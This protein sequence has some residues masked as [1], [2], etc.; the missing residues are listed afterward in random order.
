ML[1]LAVLL[2]LAQSASNEPSQL[3]W[4]D[5]T[6][7]ELPDL[8]AVH[9]NGAISLYKN[10]GDGAFEEITTGSALK[11]L[12]G[13]VSIEWSDLDGDKDVDLLVTTR[14]GV[15][16]FE[17]D[18][19]RS[20]NE[21]TPSSPLSTLNSPLTNVRLHDFDKDGLIDLELSTEREHSLWHNKG[22]WSFEQ[23]SLQ[24]PPSLSPRA[25][26]QPGVLPP[27][28]PAPGKAPA[29]EITER[30]PNGGKHNQ[31]SV[32]AEPT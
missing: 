27:G 26:I 18:E 2:S 15:R 21:A 4:A 9:P 13:A 24:L 22:K 20:L 8:A 16:L 6:G 14:A 23:V 29:G 17:N 30:D 31:R 19:R 3:A 11:D 5:F 12:K 32:R 1:H 28:Q 7:N 25:E 10:T